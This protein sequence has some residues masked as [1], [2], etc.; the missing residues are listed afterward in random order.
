MRVRFV[1]S[2]SPLFA[3]PDRTRAALKAGRITE[4]QVWEAEGVRLGKAKPDGRGHY[5]VTAAIP[6]VTVFQLSP[7]MGLSRWYRFG[8]IDFVAEMSDA[9]WAVL[10]RSAF[11]I[12]VITAHGTTV[13]QV[14]YSTL[15]R[16]EE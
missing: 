5:P 11:E 14:P 8:P 6:G 9:D 12:E 15:F 10:M 7:A 16:R 4:A 2:P 3:A 1:G 13:R